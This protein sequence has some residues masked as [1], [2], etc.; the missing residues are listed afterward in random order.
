LVQNWLNTPDQ[1]PGWAEYFLRSGHEVLIPDQP[2][3]GRSP[4][5]PGGYNLSGYSAEYISHQFTSPSGWPQARLHTQWPGPGVLGDPVFDAYYTSNAAFEGN[6][7][8]QQQRVRDAF[9]PWLRGLDREV[10]LVAHSQAG[11]FAYPLA[12]AGAVSK[13]VLLEPSGPPGEDVKFMGWPYARM[14]TRRWGLA[15]L[16]L[17]YEPKGELTL[18]REGVDSPE[19][20]SCLLQK[21]V[22]RRLISLAKVPML[23]VTSEASYHAVYD[24]CTVAF[25]R[26]AGVPV[27]W[28]ELAKQGVK[29]NAHMFFMERNGEVIY[30][31]V[32][33]W[34]AKTNLTMKN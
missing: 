32:E 16:E 12:E 11:L 3:R 27:E 15:D 6:G 1:R 29:G 4:V 7:T 18:A 23:L 31:L 30:R 17:R 28:M 22:V 33:Q 9:V 26:Q 21:G 5:P 25:L 14:P 10:V 8:L 19:R 20:S 13:V 34:I 2:L 24:H